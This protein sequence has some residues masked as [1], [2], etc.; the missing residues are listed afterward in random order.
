MLHRISVVDTDTEDVVFNDGLI[1]T[2][3]LRRQ[4]FGRHSIQTV[5]FAPGEQQC[6]DA[7]GNIKQ[8]R[9]TDGIQCHAGNLMQMSGVGKLEQ[10]GIEFCQ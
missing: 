9:R 1:V 4:K 6:F 3:I 5:T 2:E 8:A 10:K 7:E